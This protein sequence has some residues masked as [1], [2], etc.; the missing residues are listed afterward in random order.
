MKKSKTIEL[1]IAIIMVIV[2]MLIF[3]ILGSAKIDNGNDK[4]GISNNDSSQ[5]KKSSSINN[6]SVEANTVLSSETVLYSVNSNTSFYETSASGEV[7]FESSDETIGGFYTG[8][9]SKNHHGCIEID[10]K[11]SYVL[12]DAKNARLIDSAM[13]LPVGVIS[14]FTQ[15]L[16]GFS[17]CGTACL[18]MLQRNYT[19]ESEEFIPENYE[20][21][22]H[23]AE[24]RGYGDQGSLL[25]FGGGM[26]CNELQRLTKDVYGL[27]LQNAYNDLKLPSDILKTLVDSGKQAIVLVKYRNDEITN[28]NGDPHFVLIT[29]YVEV[30]GKLDFLYANSYYTAN[31]SHGNPLSH[32][33]E[34][35]LNQ[36]I[37]SYFDEPNSIMYIED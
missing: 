27:N 18:Y 16:N 15:S 20:S 28:Y 26:T 25:S 14:Q 1:V 12:I 30:E 36:S 23:F 6:S 7:I 2:V 13:V 31:I 33:D 8:R 32:I 34:D 35:M 37:S 29:G 19:Y 5:N 10:Y 24:D 17:A 11:D 22:M 9:K 3:V 4:L 21:L